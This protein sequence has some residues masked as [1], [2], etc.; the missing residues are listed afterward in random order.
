MTDTR[1]ELTL[2]TT[3]LD[4]AWSRFSFR[5]SSALQI[6]NYYL[7]AAAILSA[8]YVGALT[9]GLHI[10]AGFIGIAGSI[11]S[12]AAFLGGY[13]QIVNARRAVPQ[14]RDLEIRLAALVGTPDVWQD[15]SGHI[16][17]WT[18]RMR[19]GNIAAVMFAVA[20][21]GGLAAA[22]YGFRSG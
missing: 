12:F 18:R 3:A 7:V 16:L 2:L 11:V 4:H 14:L 8:A 13:G 6:L 17:P 22:V 5:I 21:I 10:V 9:Q 1:D 15:L 19:P 20:F